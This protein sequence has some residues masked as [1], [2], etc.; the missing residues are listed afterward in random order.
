[1]ADVRYTRQTRLVEVGERGQARLS[2]APVPLATRGEAARVERRYLE[3]AGARVGG[4]AAEAHVL[5]FEVAS[6]AAREVA[7]GAHAA[8][9]ALRRA[10][11]VTGDV[12]EERS[13]A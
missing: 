5:P 6:P 11:L 9:V 10:W 13:P 4:E 8:L 12:R 3:A 7:L 2:A 1:M